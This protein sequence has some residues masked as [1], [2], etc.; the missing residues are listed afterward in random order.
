MGDHSEPRSQPD[1]LSCEIERLAQ[2]MKTGKH[3]RGKNTKAIEQIDE[4]IGLLRRQRG[5]LLEEAEKASD[6]LEAC[7][8]ELQRVSENE[9]TVERLRKLQ[10]DERSRQRKDRKAA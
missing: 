9:R 4:L 2:E 5:A 8:G 7:Q 6:V 3:P 10:A 1:E